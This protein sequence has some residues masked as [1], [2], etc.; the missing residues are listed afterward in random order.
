MQ[1][2]PGRFDQPQL[3]AAC[4][5]C[6]PPPPALGG[7]VVE[8]APGRSLGEAEP[9]VPRVRSPALTGTPAPGAKPSKAMGSTRVRAV[10]RCSMRDH[11]CPTKQPRRTDAA[12][13]VHVGPVRKRIA[14]DE[15]APPRTPA[16][17][18]ALGPARDEFGAEVRRGV[19]SKVRRQH[20]AQP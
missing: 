19:G 12:E 11:L 1:I 3:D 18:D 16:Q 9:N 2:A 14:V 5:G 15:I 4:A 20:A 17:C 8:E 13:L 7:A 6:L 10:P